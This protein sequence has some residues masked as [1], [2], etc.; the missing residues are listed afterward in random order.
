MKDKIFFVLNIFKILVLIKQKSD[1]Y[2]LE[3]WIQFLD[4]TEFA[5]SGGIAAQATPLYPRL[6]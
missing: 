4:K 3:R 5:Y 2:L 1:C 6:N